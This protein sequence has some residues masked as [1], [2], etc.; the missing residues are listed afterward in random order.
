MGVISSRFPPA[1]ARFSE[2]TAIAANVGC[3][4]L[5]VTSGLRSLPVGNNRRLFLGNPGDVHTSYAI[6]MR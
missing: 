2:K 1:F 5:T 4:A 3:L 6:W